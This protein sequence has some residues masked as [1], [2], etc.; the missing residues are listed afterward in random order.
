MS[1]ADPLCGSQACWLRVSGLRLQHADRDPGYHRRNHEL[2]L[3]HAAA[4]RAGTTARV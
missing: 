2:E 1:S 3:A 4:A